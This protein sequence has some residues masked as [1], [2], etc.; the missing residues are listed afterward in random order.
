MKAT[1]R[2]ATAVFVPS[3]LAG[4]VLYFGTLR[5]GYGIF[6]II[7]GIALFAA[8]GVN[9]RYRLLWAPFVLV[10]AYLA[11]INFTPL[12]A[13]PPVVGGLFVLFGVAVLVVGAGMEWRGS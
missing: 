2:R 8:G 4:L 13:P 11:A 10:G 9:D 1:M 7:I 5:V 6:S 12:S 3:F